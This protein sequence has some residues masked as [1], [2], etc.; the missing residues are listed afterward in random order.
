M[1]ILSAVD[2][3]NLHLIPQDDL[4]TTTGDANISDTSVSTSWEEADMSGAL[5]NGVKAVL[6]YV[7]IRL[8]TADDKSILLTRAS[9]DSAGEV[10]GVFAQ[11]IEA[12]LGASGYIH[13]GGYIIQRVVNGKFEYRHF[14][15]WPIS[16]VRFFLRGYYR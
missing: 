1:S 15:S 3:G 5:P 12:Q 11:R 4:P 16:R 2:C 7:E 10:L 8:S 13:V 6:M 9:G 14:T